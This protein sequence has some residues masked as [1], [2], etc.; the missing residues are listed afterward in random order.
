MNRQS[1]IVILIG[2]ISSL[3]GFW[4]FDFFRDRRCGELGGIW[5]SAARQCHLAG[6][7]TVGTITMGAM[8]AGIAVAALAGFTLYRAYMYATGRARAATSR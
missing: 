1:I 8:L 4:T 5:T 3:A 7:E 2:A 6:G